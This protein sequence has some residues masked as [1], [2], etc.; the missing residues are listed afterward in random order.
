MAGE[1]SVGDVCHIAV[2]DI[3]NTETGALVDPTVLMLTVLQSDGTSAEYTYNSGDNV[4]VRDSVGNYHADIPLAV[5]G[6]WRYTWDGT[7]TGAFSKGGDF[8]VNPRRVVTP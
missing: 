7:G 5:V 4:I 2:T 1:I 8:Y 3:T 6:V